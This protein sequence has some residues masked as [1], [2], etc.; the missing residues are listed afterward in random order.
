[1]KEQFSTSYEKNKTLRI[2][3]TMRNDKITSVEITIS[4]LE[5]YCR[6]IVIKTA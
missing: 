3:K 5:L 2:A 4:D 6:T 1:L